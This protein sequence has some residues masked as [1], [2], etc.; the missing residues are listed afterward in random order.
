MSL[1]PCQQGQ[2]VIVRITTEQLKL[3][4]RACTHYVSDMYGQAA[5]EIIEEMTA[6]SNM[7]SETAQDPG[8]EGTVYGFAL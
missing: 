1:L 2:V 5:P 3:L 7:C 6:L 4:A 8:T